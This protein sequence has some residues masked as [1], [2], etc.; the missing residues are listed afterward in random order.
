M[1]NSGAIATSNTTASLRSPTRAKS[2]ALTTSNHSIGSDRA[3][4]E[5]PPDTAWYGRQDVVGAMPL[6]AVGRLGCREAVALAVSEQ[7]GVDIVQHGSGSIVSKAPKQTWPVPGYPSHPGYRQSLSTRGGAGCPVGGRGARPQAACRR[8]IGDVV[9]MALTGCRATGRRGP[10]PPPAS[11]VRIGPRARAG[12]PVN[13][14]LGRMPNCRVSKAS[15]K[16][17]GACCRPRHAEPCRECFCFLPGLESR[18]ARV[19]SPGPG[20]PWAQGR[21]LL[22]RLVDR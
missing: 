7:T 19:G 15:T 16:P 6:P 22:R 1:P 11:P 10:P 21:G 18:R 17:E 2:P 5:Q 14:F 12:Y 4:C 9:P 8:P 3:G 20:F 13:S